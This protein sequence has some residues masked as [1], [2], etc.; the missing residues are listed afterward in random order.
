MTVPLS[1]VGDAGIFFLYLK[2]YPLR[3]TLSSGGG[4]IALMNFFAASLCN[5]YKI[6]IESLKLFRE[7]EYRVWSSRGEHVGVHRRQQGREDGRRR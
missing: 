7:D 6:Y 3:R 1:M 5:M 4:G 2:K